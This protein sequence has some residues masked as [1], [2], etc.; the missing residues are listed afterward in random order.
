MVTSSRLSLDLKLARFFLYASMHEW[1][2]WAGRSV[3]PWKAPSIATILIGLPACLPSGCVCRSALTSLRRAATVTDSLPLFMQMKRAKG[4]PSSRECPSSLRRA[5]V[6]ACWA[7]LGVMTLAM[8][9]G[10]AMAAS[11]S[12]GLWP[13]PSMP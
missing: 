7:K 1:L 6:K 8:T 13:C 4:Q 5:W 10:S 3:R 2:N 11:T 12:V 9:C